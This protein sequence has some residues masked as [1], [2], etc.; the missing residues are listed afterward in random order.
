MSMINRNGNGN[1]E[2]DEDSSAA[3]GEGFRETYIRK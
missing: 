3:K 2:V 1:E